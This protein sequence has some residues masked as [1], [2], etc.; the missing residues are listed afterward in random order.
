MESTGIFS[1]NMIAVKNASGDLPK[2]ELVDDYYVHLSGNHFQQNKADMS[3]NIGFN[4]YCVYKLDPISSSRDDTFIVQNALFGVMKI[5][6]NA[7]TSKYKMKDME[8]VLMREVVL[9]K[10]ILVMVEMY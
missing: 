1:S 6:N 2:L 8:L 7:D 9:V 4:I 5:T 3:N 10:E